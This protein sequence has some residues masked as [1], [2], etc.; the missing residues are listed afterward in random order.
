MRARRTDA[1]QTDIVDAMR[2]AGATVEVL[3][4]VGDGVADLC[5]RVAGSPGWWVEVKDGAKAPS[6]R[7]LTDDEI[8]FAGRW[9]GYYVIIESVDE[10]LAFVSGLREVMMAV[11]TLH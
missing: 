7:R 10:A 3:S 9:D 6:A 8:A 1:N 2:K 11:D 5:V 4:H